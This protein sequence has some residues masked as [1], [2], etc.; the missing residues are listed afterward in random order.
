MYKLSITDYL[1][2][3]PKLRDLK[4]K[5]TQMFIISQFLSE[6]Q[7]ELRSHSRPLIG[8]HSR[9]LLGPQIAQIA[10]PE[11]ETLPSSCRWLKAGLS[12][13]VALVRA[14]PRSLSH[15]PIHRAA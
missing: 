10:G 4:K 12:F 14:L 13:P 1:P 7:E 11:E 5:T 6:I 8:L 15:G 2:H 9:C 3:N